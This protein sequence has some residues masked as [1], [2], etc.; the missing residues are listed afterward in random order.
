M[1]KADRICAKKVLIVGDD[2]LASGTGMVRDMKTKIQTDVAL[3]NLEED[4]KKIL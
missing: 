1:K 2:E 3:D 4:I